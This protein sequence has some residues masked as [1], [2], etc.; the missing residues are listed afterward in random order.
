[1][2]KV[3]V[4]LTSQNASLNNTHRAEL[5]SPSNEQSVFQSKEEFVFVFGGF[6]VN[7]FLNS[8]EVLD[9]RTGIWRHFKQVI[10]GRTQGA[11][12]SMPGKDGPQI[13]LVGGRD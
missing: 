3:A 12:V 13:W 1:M 5:L 8:V 10:K 4:D 2:P 6:N 11:A 9:V 7:G